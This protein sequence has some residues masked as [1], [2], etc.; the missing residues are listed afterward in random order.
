MEG[1]SRSA[2]PKPLSLKPPR[3]DRLVPPGTRGPLLAAWCRLRRS[4]AL[5][6]QR[7]YVDMLHG[8]LLVESTWT[9][10][11]DNRPFVGLAKAVTARR[12][13][14]VPPD[15]LPALAGHLELRRATAAGLAVQHRP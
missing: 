6:L 13:L 10:P 15:I 8:T 12:T 11:A 9:A 4:E 5:E 14:A 2:S 3:T 7:Q 1:S